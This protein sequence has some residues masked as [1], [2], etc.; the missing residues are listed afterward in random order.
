MIRLHLVKKNI[1]V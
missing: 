1:R